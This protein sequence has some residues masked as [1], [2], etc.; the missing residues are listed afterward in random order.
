VE[1]NIMNDDLDLFGPF[2]D[3]F[4]E[5]IDK[6]R[7]LYQSAKVK[8]TLDLDA[9]RLDAEVYRHLTLA[10]TLLEAAEKHLETEDFAKSLYFLIRAVANYNL[11][12]GDKGVLRQKATIAPAGLTVVRT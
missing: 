6:Q 4:K 11:V 12:L 5:E 8:A 1:K 7:R 3:I 2:R 9:G 10:L